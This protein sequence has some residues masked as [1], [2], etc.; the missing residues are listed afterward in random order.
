[1]AFTLNGVGTRYQGERWLPD[2]TY[3]TTKWFVMFFVPLI[4][5]GSVRVLSRG[6]PPWAAGMTVQEVPLDLAMVAQ[7]YIWIIGVILFLVAL[8]QIL[9]WLQLHIG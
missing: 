7:T 2:G 5:L 9:P 8:R 1:M 6:G 3:V 4:P